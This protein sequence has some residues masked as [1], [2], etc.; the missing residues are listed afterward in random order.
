MDLTAE[1]LVDGLSNGNILER[2]RAG[3]KLNKALSDPGEHRCFALQ[4]PRTV[5]ELSM[6]L[7]H[8]NFLSDAELCF[9]R[10]GLCGCHKGPVQCFNELTFCLRSTSRRRRPLGQA[11]GG[12]G[13]VC[14]VQ[15]L[16]VPP[17]RSD[18]RH[19]KCFSLL[20]CWQATIMDAVPVHASRSILMGFAAAYSAGILMAHAPEVLSKL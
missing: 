3:I 15:P 6:S 13:G 20:A 8:V 19:G 5:T 12:S 9:Y 14:S 18:P 16:D 11:G 1:Q 7:V 10:L 4:V 2:E 17:R